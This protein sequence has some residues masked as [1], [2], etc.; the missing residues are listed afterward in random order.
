MLAVYTNRGNILNSPWL[1]LYEIGM[2]LS[3]VVEVVLVVIALHRHPVLH[4]FLKVAVGLSLCL[5]VLTNHTSATIASRGGFL[6]AWTKDWSLYPFLPLTE[7]LVGLF[8]KYV[9]LPTFLGPLTD[10][11]MPLLLLYMVVSQYSLLIGPFFLLFL[12]VTPSF[13]A[14][15][16]FWFWLV[17]SVLYVILPSR[18]WRWTGGVLRRGWS[19]VLHRTQM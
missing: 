19:M 6:Q 17:L 2:L 9:T 8:T 4:R 7:K 12:L 10:Q 13:L 15:P 16:I 5:M 11:N 18:A 14:L 3:P 1:W